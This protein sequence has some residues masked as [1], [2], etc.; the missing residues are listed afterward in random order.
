MF[1]ALRQTWTEFNQ[2][3]CPRMAAALAYYTLFALPALLVLTVT[4]A[5]FF[6]QK[7]EVAASLTAYFEE[8]IGPAAAKEITT[9]IGR[10]GQTGNGLL[11]SAMGIVLLLVG[12]TG[13][14][15]E[16]QNALNRIW[17]VRPDP[18]QSG[19]GT[20]IVKR[21]L[22]LGMLLGVAFMLLTSL[23][24]SWLLSA[25]A[26]QIQN[27]APEWLSSTA[28]WALNAGVSLAIIALLFAGIFKYV[29]DAT[30]GWREVWPGALLTA[31]LFVIGKSLFGVYLA[32]ANPTSAFGVA[33]SL[34]LILLW[35]YYSALIVFI[36]AEFTEVWAR[37]HG[38]D[39]Q[40]ESGAVRTHK[41][42]A[43]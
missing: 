29:P 37:Q 34:A 41:M 42:P 25:F 36:G 19:W 21:M 12:A 14:L 31:V 39:P 7:E 33:G 23:V 1:R 32:Y 24:I 13:A 35:I 16:L 11:G 43:M 38:A 3:E 22:S 30:I 28:L 26:Q 4:V 10:A 15:A 9:M 40:P 18:K 17:E 8:S 6:V 20:F 2:D 5:G 27:W